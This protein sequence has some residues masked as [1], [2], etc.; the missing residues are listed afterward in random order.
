MARVASGDAGSQRSGQAVS[1]AELHL[2][3][4]Q[5]QSRGP[6][7]PGM[8][9]AALPP[10]PTPEAQDPVRNYLLKPPSRPSVPL[11]NLS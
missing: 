5:T 10:P 2:K 9:P 3:P 6:A 1:P 4:R 7:C 8:M 11:V